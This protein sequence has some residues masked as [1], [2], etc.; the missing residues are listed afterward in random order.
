[1]AVVTVNTGSDLGIPFSKSHSM[2]ARPVF[3]FLINS[4]IG[5][6]LFHVRWI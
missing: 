3:L 4:D 1:M 5:L 2:A 6:K